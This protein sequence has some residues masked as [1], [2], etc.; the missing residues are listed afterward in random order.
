MKIQLKNQIPFVGDDLPLGNFIPHSRFTRV[1]NFINDQSRIV[2][3]TSDLN[4]FAAN[5]IY[6][7]G[8]RLTDVKSL[9]IF[10]E[11]ILIDE[12]CFDLNKIEIYDSTFQYDDVDHT[13]F[14]SRLFQIPGLFP[15]LFPEKSL[16]FLYVPER[17]NFFKSGFDRQFMLNALEAKDRIL[18]GDVI[19]GILNI[20]GR[21][22]GLTPSGDDFIAGF[23]L[24]LHFNEVMYDADL[25]ALRDQV[26][27]AASGSNPL[28]NAFLLNAKNRNYF[29]PLKKILL[30]L[31][32]EFHAPVRKSLED[33][34]S[35]G[36]TSGADFFSGYMLPIKYKTGI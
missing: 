20:R 19:G 24:G 3:L 7:P 25:S 34:L 5:A 1:I 11:K 6:I 35:V 21:G 18:S 10:P 13:A 9:S 30:L 27:V 26:F 2:Y 28:I 16:V 17:E 36:S 32:E 15:E 31:C 29:R 23:L 4:L 8:T 22:Y 33:L 12:M 14:Q